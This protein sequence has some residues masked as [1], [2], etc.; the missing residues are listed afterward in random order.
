MYETF[1][2]HVEI[3][4][5]RD[6]TEVRDAVAAATELIAQRLL[7]NGGDSVT[8]VQRPDHVVA[9]YEKEMPD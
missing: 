6:R 8:T 4:G 3:S 2:V 7:L 9:A 5:D 1:T